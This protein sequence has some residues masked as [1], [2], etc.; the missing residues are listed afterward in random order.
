M[1]TPNEWVHVKS[2]LSATAT[3]RDILGRDGFS[4]FGEHISRSKV[5]ALAAVCWKQLLTV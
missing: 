5:R 1:A 2:E 4:R 3:R